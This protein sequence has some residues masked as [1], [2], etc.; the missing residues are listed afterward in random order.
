MVMA[1]PCVSITAPVTGV[2]SVSASRPQFKL[3][4]I[5]ELARAKGLANRAGEWQGQQ[6]LADRVGTL[7]RYEAER[8]R[9]SASPVW[10]GL[11]R[12][13]ALGRKRTLARVE[14][15][16][17]LADDEVIRCAYLGSRKN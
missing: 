9:P 2:V 3:C 1:S 5:Q 4:A 17:S 10:A 7:S 11:S 12:A 6:F 16:D 13:S 8:R 15:R 14:P